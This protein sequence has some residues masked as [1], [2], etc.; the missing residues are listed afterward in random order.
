MFGIV[1]GYEHMGRGGGALGGTL[2]Y[3]NGE[4]AVASAQV[5]SNVVASM[6]EGSLYYR[7][8][9]GGLRFG[10]RGGGGYAFF[11]ATRKFLEPGAADSATSSWGGYFV[12]GSVSVAYE[13]KF[14]RFYARPQFSADY[15]RLGEGGHSENGGGAGFNLTL[16]GRNSSRLSGDAVMVLGTQWGTTSWVRAELR[17][18]YREILAGEIGDTIASFAGGDPFNMAADKSTGGWATFG[19][20]LKAGSAYSYLALEGDAEIR[21]GERQYNLRVAGRSIF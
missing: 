15:L 5:G 17:G 1:A 20:S 8:A 12:D 16:A 2:A 10:V 13:Q 3:L 19:F 11:S 4:E 21:S 14:G 6:I 9:V 7:R 18:G